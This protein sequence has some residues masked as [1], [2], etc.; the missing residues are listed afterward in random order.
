MRAAC[1]AGFGLWLRSRGVAIL[2]P[3]FLPTRFFGA[4]FFAPAAFFAL[5]FFAPPDA[6]SRGA[7][8]RPDAFFALARL[9]G[10]RLG[11]GAAVDFLARAPPL[12]RRP[13]VGSWMDSPSASASASTPPM[14]EGLDSPASSSSGM[15]M[16]LSNSSFMMRLSSE[17]LVVGASLDEARRPRQALPQTA[18]T[19]VNTDTKGGHGTHPLA[20]RD[21]RMRIVCSVSSVVT[22]STGCT[23]PESHRSRGDKRRKTILGRG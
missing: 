3:A 1:R 16:P 13:P 21:L 4:D 9:A 11:E 19:T 23:H 8:P 22:S 10:G 12:D 18:L 14:S 17:K 6:A 20:L 7:R 15:P 2:A 5:A